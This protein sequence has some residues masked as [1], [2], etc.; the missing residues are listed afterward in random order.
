MIFVSGAKTGLRQSAGKYNTACL[1]KAQKKGMFSMLQATKQGRKPKG[2]EIEM[3]EYASVEIYVP[4]E[5][6]PGSDH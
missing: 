1:L 5:E 6:E 4:G 3:E 2:G